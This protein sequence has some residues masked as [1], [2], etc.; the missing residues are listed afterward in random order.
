MAGKVQSGGVK[1]LIVLCLKSGSREREMKTDF[2]F[3]PSRIQSGTLVHGIAP[4]MSGT[5]VHGMVPSMSG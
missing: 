5:P 3:L 1:Q 4:S 2:L